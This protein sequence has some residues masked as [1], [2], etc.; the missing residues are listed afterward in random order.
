MY[1][2]KT[3][4]IVG[5][6][7]IILGEVHGVRENIEIIKTFIIA[8]EEENISVTLAL[9]WPS[10]INS[11]ISVFLNNA[12]TTPPWRGWDFVQD[13]DG[14]ISKEHIALLQWLKVRNNALSVNKKHSV[15]GFSE[16]HKSWNERD[17][18]MA[19]NISLLSTN[20][21]KKVVLAVMGNLHAQRQ[22]LTFDGESHAPLATHLPPNDTVIFKCDYRCGAYFNYTV[23]IFNGC[24]DCINENIFIKPSTTKEVDYCVIV[25]CAHVVSLLDS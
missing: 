18:K 15:F 10:E 4:E 21:K 11:D 23:Q 9:E 12:E 14:R 17:L 25:P 24:K 8:L 20:D 2:L 6:K 7:I 5:K 3:K 1:N 13:K 22:E 19:K 16:N